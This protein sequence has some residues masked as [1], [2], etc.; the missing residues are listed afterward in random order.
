MTASSVTSTCKRSKRSERRGS[1]LRAHLSSF[2]CSRPS[3]VNCFFL[4]C[5]CAKSRRRGAGG[6]S[7]LRQGGKAA[8]RQGGEGVRRMCPAKPCVRTTP[9]VSEACAL[10]VS[11][12]RRG[13]TGSTPRRASGEEAQHPGEPLAKRI[14]TQASPASDQVFTVH[15]LENAGKLLQEAGAGEGE[16]LFVCVIR[17]L[18]SRFFRVSVPRSLRSLLFLVCVIRSLHSLFFRVSVPHLCWTWI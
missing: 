15:V 1:V 13:S 12:W 18:H 8:R 10:F 3:K 7:V 17:S 9:G 16:R 11:L 2:L 5:F 14:N 6:C 4:I